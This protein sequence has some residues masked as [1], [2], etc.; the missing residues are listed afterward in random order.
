LAAPTV[1]EQRAEPGEILVG[2]EEEFFLV[3]HAT[4]ELAPRIS[5]VLQPAEAMA[6]DQAQ[7]ELHRAQ[8]E[9][10]SNPC[11]TLDAL[12]SDLL[13]L[14]QTMVAAATTKRCSVVASGTYPGKMGG[15]GRL[16]T[17]DD[18]YEAMERENQ[19]LVREQVI[20]G[21]HIH[22]TAPDPTN[23]IR[24][25]NAIRR[26][27]PTLLA[28]SSNS[29]FWEEEDTGFA[30]FRTEVWARWPTAGP[31]GA[32]SSEDEYDELVRQLIDAGV[33][34]DEAMA[35]WDVRPSKRFPTLEIRTADVM[36]DVET[37]VTL[38]ALARALVE[39]CTS[40]EATEISLRPELL[41]AATW[42]AA[43]SGLEGTL[44]DPASGRAVPARQAVD[45]LLRE[46]AEP[47]DARGELEQV[48]ASIDALFEHGTGAARQ[49]VAFERHH[50]LDEV[51]ESCTLGAD[52]T[53]P[54]SALEP[55]L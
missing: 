12:R 32:F 19:I 4:G 27:L 31:I 16:I 40:S 49:R 30:S 51:I 17:P 6:G 42:R 13:G 37:A 29:P 28:L 2:V 53:A 11:D 33:M 34:L 50:R 5:A 46:V 52:G 44:L 9:L 24:T 8:I 7:A 47:L 14:R 36:A 38:A 23:R 26:W 3:E 22:V 54:S 18:R 41:K 20:C 43:V 55:A 10:A 48:S 35:Y 45:E 21:C 25:M 15:A 39:R 1:A